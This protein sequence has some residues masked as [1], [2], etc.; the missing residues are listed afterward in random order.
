M[1]S[2]ENTPDTLSSVS[3]ARL[4]EEVVRRAIKQFV[5]ETGMEFLF[6]SIQFIVHEGRFQGAEAQPRYRLYKSAGRL[7]PVP[8]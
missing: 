2:N 5:T 6:G 7:F 4:Y 1:D 8:V 3:N